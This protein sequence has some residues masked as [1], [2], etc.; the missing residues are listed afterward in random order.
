[1]KNLRAIVLLSALVSSISLSAQNRPIPINEP[2]LS[3][4]KLFAGL[5]DKIQVSTSDLESLFGSGLGRSASIMLSMDKQTK[6]E[7]EVVSISAKTDDG[8]Q[9]MVIR[10]TNFNGARFTLSKR[11]QPDGT[12]AYTGRIISFQHGDLYEL[13]NQQGQYILVKRNFYDL[14]NE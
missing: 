14:V 11:E 3:K 10:S 4:P 6:L 1:M 9:S 13:Q 8:I 5:P 2:D 12:F 7:G